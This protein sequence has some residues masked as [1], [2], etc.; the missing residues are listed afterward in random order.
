MKLLSRYSTRT[1]IA[2]GLLGLFGC[3]ERQ[4]EGPAR[5]HVSGTVT[6]E[7]KPVPFG[8]ISFVP[9]E[10]SNLPVSGA[11]IHEG[12][13]DVINNGGV[14]VGKHRVEINGWEK[15]PQATGAADVSSVN[16]KPLIPEKFNTKS[17]LTLTIESSSPISK[18]FELK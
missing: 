3:S 1:C 4:S 12:K 11:E 13:Y 6:F 17:E 9:F 14:P 7:G 2:A 10:G 18:N 8:S 5:S 15:A 16:I